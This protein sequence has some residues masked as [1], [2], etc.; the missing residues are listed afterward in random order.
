MNVSI[1]NPKGIRKPTKYK[2]DVINCMVNRL[3]LN[4][5]KYWWNKLIL[6]EGAGNAK[7]ILY[8]EETVLWMPTQ[9]DVGWRPNLKFIEFPE[10]DNG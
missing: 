10:L 8:M 3:R 2:L 9:S 4:S 7:V 1:I 5:K 6:K